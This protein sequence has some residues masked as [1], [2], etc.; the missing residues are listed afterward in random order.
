MPLSVVFRSKLQRLRRMKAGHYR[1]KRLLQ[2]HAKRTE[3]KDTL[4][5]SF[6]FFVTVTISRTL[7]TV[8]EAAAEDR[9]EPIEVRPMGEVKD[10]QV[11]FA[12]CL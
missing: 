2:K 11:R 12:V 4:H 3:R 10:V 7:S 8:S 6:Q 9:D 5:V 1:L